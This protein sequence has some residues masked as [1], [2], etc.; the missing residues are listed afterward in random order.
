MVTRLKA[1]FL[2]ARRLR[3]IASLSLL[4]F[5][6]C[7]SSS[8]DNFI[9]IN[10]FNSESYIDKMFLDC[11]D[12]QYNNENIII[13]NETECFSYSHYLKNKEKYK[14]ERNLKMLCLFIP[15]GRF[16]DALYLFV[17]E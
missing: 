7:S 2:L 14:H 3:V 6:A 16:V 13:N 11:L 8:D 5:A 1:F 17:V 4:F 10:T 15:S 12:R 9:S